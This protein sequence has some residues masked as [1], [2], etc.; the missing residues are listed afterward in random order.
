MPHPPPARARKP[1]GRLRAALGADAA[2]PRLA[3]RRAPPA[4]G[5]KCPARPPAGLRAAGC[6]HCRSAGALSPAPGR[7]GALLEAMPLSE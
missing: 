3:A 5:A 1:R 4:G 7:P 6:G 2:P